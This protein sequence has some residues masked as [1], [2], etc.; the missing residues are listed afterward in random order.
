MIVIL[1]DSD[2]DCNY[3]VTS[4]VIKLE[5]GNWHGSTY[6]TKEE[7]VCL[8]INVDSRYGIMLTCIF[9]LHLLPV[10]HKI[11]TDFSWLFT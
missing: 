5:L 1:C 10:Q 6:G 9:I 4:G 7:N 11:I 2:C 8:V 3:F